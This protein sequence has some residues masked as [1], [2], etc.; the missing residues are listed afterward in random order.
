MPSFFVHGPEMLRLLKMFI[1]T[2]PHDK[3]KTFKSGWF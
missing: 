2:F 3:G 1:I